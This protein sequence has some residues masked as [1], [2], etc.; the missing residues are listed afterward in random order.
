MA[1]ETIKKFKTPLSDLPAVSSETQGYSLRYR[2]VSDDKNRVSHWSPIYLIDPDFTYVP[3]SPLAHNNSND[4]NNVV[5]GQVSI[6]K[7][8]TVIS[9]AKQY[10]IW[11]KW[12]KNTDGTNGDWIYQQRTETNSIVLQTPSSYTINGT[13]INLKPNRLRVEIYIPGTPVQRVP[14]LLVYDNNGTPFSV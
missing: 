12:N 4:I 7:S 1:N 2:I 8:G 14:F 9:I 6:T 10:D 11:L 3:G 5:W 13:V